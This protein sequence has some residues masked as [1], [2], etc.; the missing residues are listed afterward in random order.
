MDIRAKLPQGQGIWPAIWM[1][2]TE[3][4]YGAWPLSGEI[5]IMEAVNTNAA[6]ANAVYGTLHYGNPGPTI[7]T[8]APTTL[9][10]RPFGRNFTPIQWNGKLARFAGM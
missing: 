4:V 5:D 6:G 2:P 7:N 3:S 1:L 10:P 8:P 9:P